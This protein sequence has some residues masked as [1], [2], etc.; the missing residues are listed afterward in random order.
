MPGF[1]DSEAIAV[2]PTNP[3]DAFRVPTVEKVNGFDV[4]L[5][6]EAGNGLTGPPG[7]TPYRATIQIRNLTR[8]ALVTVT[9]NAANAAGN[10]GVGQAWNTNDEEFIFNVAGGSADINPGDFL[11]VIGAVNS[12]NPIGDA[13]NDFSNV[14]SGVFQ[15]I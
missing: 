11:E 15:V 10:I 5:E 6:A 13:T 3:G 9:T 4:H 7:V 1:N 8:F 14:R 2:Y 12:G